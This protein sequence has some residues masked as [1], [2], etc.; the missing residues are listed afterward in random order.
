[1]TLQT[2]RCVLGRCNSTSRGV[3]AGGLAPSR[4]EIQHYHFPFIVGQFARAYCYQASAAATRGFPGA[5]AKRPIAE[6]K[7]YHS[8]HSRA[9]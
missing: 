3:L 1:M 5:R 7:R 9:C 6:H 4:V 2:L 8:Q